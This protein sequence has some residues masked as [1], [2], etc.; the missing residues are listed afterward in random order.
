MASV[1]PTAEDQGS[2]RGESWLEV[3][4]DLPRWKRVPPP[5]SRWY[6]CA[7]A[8]NHS[9]YVHRLSL[10]FHDPA[11]EDYYHKA[12]TVPSKQRMLNTYLLMSLLQN[13]WAIMSFVWLPVHYASNPFTSIYLI[14]LSL[15]AT[16][17]WFVCFR[18][19]VTGPSFAHKYASL[20]LPWPVH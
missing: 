11:L 15:T 2:S 5:T 10:K 16:I 19:F 20:R 17:T 13:L 8:A 9:F 1:A 18:I 7:S 6:K 4:S 14:V 12:V 3:P